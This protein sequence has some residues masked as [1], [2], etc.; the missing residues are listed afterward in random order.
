[1]KIVSINGSPKGKTSNTNVMI[2]ALLKGFQSSD[3]EIHE[4]LLSEKDIRYCKGC[5]SCW[6]KT[7]GR[8]IIDDDMKGLIEIMQGTD[9]FIIGTPLYFNNVSGTLKVFIDRLTATGGNPHENSNNP[10]QPKTPK[11]IAVS[12][13]GFPNR[14]QFN[15]VSSWLTTFVSMIKGDLIGEFYTTNGKVLTQANEEQANSRSKYLSYLENCGKQY[16]E[17]MELDDEKKGILSRNILDF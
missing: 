7:P 16:L 8:Y 9:V 4:I 11:F 10:I 3:S 15:I 17:K 12:N 1:M 13:C 14:S 6:T 2:E 5:Y